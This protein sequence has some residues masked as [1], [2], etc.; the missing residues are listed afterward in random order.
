MNL[1]LCRAGRRQSRPFCG[2]QPTDSEWSTTKP[3]YALFI[4]HTYNNYIYCLCPAKA[5]GPQTYL[6]NPK[7]LSMFIQVSTR[8]YS[9]MLTVVWF[10]FYWTKCQYCDFSCM[11]LHKYMTQRCWLQSLRGRGGGVNMSLCGCCGES[12][13]QSPA[14]PLPLQQQDTLMTSLPLSSDPPFCSFSWKYKHGPKGCDGIFLQ[15]T[16]AQ[17]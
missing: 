8:G 12:S 7:E 4:P 3:R 9:S 15:F 13:E 16:N 2:S 1:S 5:T 11:L 10:C 6:K 14:E 17:L